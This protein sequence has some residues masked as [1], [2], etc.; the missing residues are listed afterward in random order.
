MPRQW[1][2]VWGGGAPSSSLLLPQ[3]LTLTSW[4]GDW[5]EV[6]GCGKIQRAILERA[7]R[8]DQHAW[9]FGM[10]LERLAM[11]LYGIPDIRLFWSEDERFLRQ[12]KEG[13]RPT[14]EPFSKYPPCTKDITFWVDDRF[15]E[16][17]FHELARSVAG[18]LVENVELIDDFTHPTT[19]RHSNCFRV[20]Y[21]AMDRSLTN[22][23]VDQL[24]VSSPPQGGRGQSRAHLTRNAPS[25]IAHS[26]SS[27]TR[28]PPGATSC[29]RALN[30][31]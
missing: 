24:Q 3:F 5:L 18:D 6:L 23:E 30:A 1:G 28:L 10:G 27:A 7:G 16:N 14:F 2:T 29:G 8:G 12:F 4:Q 17:D 9:A 20:I 25:P 22:E 26:S 19:G 11:R 21:R 15:H 13:T 31:P